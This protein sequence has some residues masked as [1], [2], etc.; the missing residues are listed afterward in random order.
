MWTNECECQY[1]VYVAACAF[2]HKACP[3]ISTQLGSSQTSNHLMYYTVWRVTLGSIK[4]RK[5]VLSHLSTDHVAPVFVWSANI[6]ANKQLE[7][8]RVAT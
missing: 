7:A 6:T 4:F 5:M 2:P 8:T 1:N 3:Y